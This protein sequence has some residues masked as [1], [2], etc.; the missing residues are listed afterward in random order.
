MFATATLA[1]RIERA[2]KGLIVEAARS[3]GH[4]LP[5]GQMLIEEFAGAAAVYVEPGAPFNKVAGAGF[6]GAPAVEILDSI[7][8]QYAERGSPVQFEVSSLGDPVVVRTL[9]TRGYELVGFE[10]VLGLAIDR[11]SPMQHPDEVHI[12][13]ADPGDADVWLDTVVT[14]FLHADVFDGPP[15]H[16]TISRDVLEPIF[17]DMAATPSFERYLARRGDSVAGAA[18]LRIEDGVAQLAG[19]ATLPQHRRRGVQTALLAHRLAEA[20]ARGCDVAVVTTQPGSKSQENVQRAG[21][22]LLYTRAIL[23]KPSR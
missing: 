3:S 21:F 13:R 1:K 2:E 9:T 19:A 6:D 23:V 14:G 16:E 22:S 17:R 12:S 15:S 4:R 8:R 20:A 11:R 7:E 18:S 10:N 5:P